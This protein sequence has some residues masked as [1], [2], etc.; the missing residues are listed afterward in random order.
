MVRLPPLLA[1]LF[2]VLV[3]VKAGTDNVGHV[4]FK[5]REY[6]VDRVND[7]GVL[8]YRKFKNSFLVR[9]DMKRA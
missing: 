2:E 9:S 6:I 8:I 4:P 7:S 1:V 5:S 3:D